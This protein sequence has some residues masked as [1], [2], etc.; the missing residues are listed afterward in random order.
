M[1]SKWVGEPDNLLSHCTNCFITVLSCKEKVT[2]LLQTFV[3]T[4]VIRK[5]L[6]PK[7][8]AKFRQVLPPVDKRCRRAL[9]TDH[10][11]AEPG[12]QVNSCSLKMKTLHLVNNHLH[13]HDYYQ[14][15]SLPGP[16][17]HPVPSRGFESVPHWS[18]LARRM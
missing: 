3:N 7:K 14:L 5:N 18:P 10:R 2:T 17:T 16:L 13:Q 4:D 6:F 12:E 9:H 8:N 1:S 11:H 15:T